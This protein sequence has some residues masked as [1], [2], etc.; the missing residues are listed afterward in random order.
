MQTLLIII[1]LLIASALIFAV[2]IQRDE[3]KKQKIIQ[4]EIDLIPDSVL[5]VIAELEIVGHK[6]KNESAQFDFNP[7]RDKTRLKNLIA[8]KIVLESRLDDEQFFNIKGED[9]NE[10]QT[11][12]DNGD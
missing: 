6:I 9:T 4:P 2:I 11:Q 3:Q 10:Q 12:D 1:L 8:T 7:H 5:E